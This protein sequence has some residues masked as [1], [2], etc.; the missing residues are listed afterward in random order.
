MTPTR[1]SQTLVA[2]V[3]VALGAL[4]LADVTACSTDAGSGTCPAFTKDCADG[5]GP[6]DTDGDGCPDQCRPQAIDAATAD[7]AT[8]DAAAP[9]DGAATDTAAPSA[10]CQ[11]DLARDARCKSTV[12]CNTAT[13]C[14][15]QEALSNPDMRDAAIACWTSSACGDNAVDRCALAYLAAKTRSAGQESFAAQYC[16]TCGGA[17]A[18]TACTTRVLH[19]DA[20]AGTFDKAGIGAFI[21]LQFSDA[22]LAQIE[23]QCLPIASA[24]AGGAK[25]CDELLVGCVAK[26]FL[27]P[28]DKTCK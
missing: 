21:A 12:V 28:V 6:T 26:R 15:G 27:A 10:F 14:S 9:T 16:A 13:V 3:M 7:V 22:V 20:D 24:D 11:A 23:Q 19:P 5:N 1:S 8:S 25:T 18:G 4:A 17:D 2:L